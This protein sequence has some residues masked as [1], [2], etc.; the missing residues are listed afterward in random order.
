MVGHAVQGPIASGARPED[1][2]DL[3][4]RTALPDDAPCFVGRSDFY[5]RGYVQGS[6][7]EAS[8]D[9]FFR[10]LAIFIDRGAPVHDFARFCGIFPA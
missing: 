1:V 10:Q 6:K 7:A 3:F 2:R 9:G 8:G 5:K 4:E